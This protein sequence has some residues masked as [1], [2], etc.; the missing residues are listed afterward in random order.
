MFTNI[1]VAEHLIVALDA[2]GSE[3]SYE[4]VR[5]MV[6]SHGY[7]DLHSLYEGLAEAKQEVIK[8]LVWLMDTDSLYLEWIFT[9]LFL[10]EL[11][12]V[13]KEGKA[14]IITAITQS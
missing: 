1:R 9:G 14:T 4:A 12:E 5:E 13:S 6:S 8:S 7:F 11:V 10:N 3:A 2:T